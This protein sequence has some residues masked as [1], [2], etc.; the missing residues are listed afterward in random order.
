MELISKL[1]KKDLSNHL[2]ATYQTY[3][4]QNTRNLRSVQNVLGWMCSSTLKFP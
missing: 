2:I 1:N 4:T 3:F